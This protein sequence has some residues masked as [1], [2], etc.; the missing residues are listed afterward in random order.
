MEVKL[1]KLPDV[2]VGKGSDDA[3]ASTTTPL[4]EVREDGGGV[5]GRIQVSKGGIRWWKGSTQ[6]YPAFVRWD[7][8]VNFMES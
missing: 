2:Q 8:F 6:K 4:F 7:D 5:V 1:T 3:R